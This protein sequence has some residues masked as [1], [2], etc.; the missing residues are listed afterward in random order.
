MPVGSQYVFFGKMS[1]LL[2]I[3]DWVLCFFDIEF[4]EM[5]VYFGY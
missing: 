3:F 5:F 1:G 2:P 4:Y